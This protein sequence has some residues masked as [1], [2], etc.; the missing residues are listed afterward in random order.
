M[1]VSKLKNG[2][3][4][5]GDNMDE[6]ITFNHTYEALR[7][8]A[9]ALRDIYKGKL[10]DNDH[11]ASRELFNTIEYHVN[12]NNKSIDV[13]FN[14]QDYW[15][16]VEDDTRP[17]FPPLKAI[18]EWVRVKPVLPSTTYNGKL[19]TE[20]QLAFLI[21]RKISEDGTKGTHDLEKA[22]NDANAEFN[23]IISDAISLDIN[24]C[25]D[26]LLVLG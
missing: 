23:Q 14:L 9:E 3:K 4:N 26:R 17:H 13:K 7:Q 22:R 5:K 15:K 2:N 25:L 1:N 18:L 20:Q 8:Y 12:I 24:E 19:P 16:Y 10:L 21:A 6:L 11:L